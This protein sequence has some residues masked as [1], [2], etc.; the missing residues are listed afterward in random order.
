[1]VKKGFSR[2]NRENPFSHSADPAGAVRVCD[3]FDPRCRFGSPF[4]WR[5]A[6]GFDWRFRFA[7]P[8]RE[9]SGFR[10]LG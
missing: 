9:G 1:M 8:P 4:A 6:R 3:A 7:S 5:W 10:P 2:V